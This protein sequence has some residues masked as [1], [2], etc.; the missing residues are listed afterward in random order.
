MTNESLRNEK[1]MTETEFIEWYRKEE[2]D[3]YEKPSVTTDMLIFTVSDKQQLNNRK[4]AEKELK[5]LLIKRKDHPFIGQWAI[6]GG[7]MNMNED[8]QVT[9][10][11]ELKEETN[12]KDVY[13]EQ[14]YTWGDVGRDPRMRVVS[15]SYMAL[16]DSTGLNVQ[17]G[18]DAEDAKWFAVER[19]I[20]DTKKQVLEGTLTIIK[21][22]EVQLVSDDGENIILYTL[23][24]TTTVERAN[25]RTTIEVVEPSSKSNRLAFDHV[26]IVNYGLDRLQ[27]KL[28]YTP[29]A[30]NLMPTHFT[31][32]ELQLV[33]EI[34]LGE[35]LL[36]ANFRR[37]IMPM[38][39]ETEQYKSDSAHRP[40]KLYM[41]NPEYVLKS[42]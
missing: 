8:I 32:S 16:V 17:A 2:K 29:I 37:K 9:A 23:I 26:K 27:N 40:S 28:A 30:F 3:K 38:L 36:K 11:R 35:K 34:I 25:F 18:D 12:V 14:L 1:G 24:E 15:T 20:V 22:I 31:L 19:T 5:V 41:Y 10:E 42:F 33:Y 6:P 13:M 21:N 7:F 39:I 4:L